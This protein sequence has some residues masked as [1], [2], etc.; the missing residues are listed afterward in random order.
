MSPTSREPLC[1][2]PVLSQSPPLEARRGARRTLTAQRHSRETSDS[3]WRVP[4]R[5][6]GGQE[7]R[8]E[9]S[10]EDHQLKHHVQ[11]YRSS[12]AAHELD[13]NVRKVAL[14]V[15]KSKEAPFVR[16]ATLT[17]ANRLRNSQADIG[18]YTQRE[19]VIALATTEDR[20]HSWLRT[21]ELPLSRARPA[22][23][24]SWS[25]CSRYPNC[26][27]VL[28]GIVAKGGSGFRACIALFDISCARAPNE[29]RVARTTFRQLLNEWQSITHRER[30]ARGRAR[31]RYPNRRPEAR[32]PRGAEFGPLSSRSR[33][34]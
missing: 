7:G 4:G 32:R 24:S 17:A 26:S 5:D 25:K 1:D 31:G 6:K 9:D 2:L 13:V 30:R 14:D 22:K 12:N 27:V 19:R 23:P 29:S 34:T 16:R 15:G 10:N 20:S 18:T 28:A 33:G 21:S 8:D 11:S 3:L